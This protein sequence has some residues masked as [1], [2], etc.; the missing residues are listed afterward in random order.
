MVGL[1][2]SV[3]YSDRDYPSRSLELVRLVLSQTE[4]HAPVVVSPRQTSTLCKPVLI[5]VNSG[6]LWVED[7]Q[8]NNVSTLGIEAAQVNKKHDTPTWTDSTSGILSI[9]KIPTPEEDVH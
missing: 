8:E 4:I 6:V 5:P 1:G 7:I 9:E 3:V 2:V